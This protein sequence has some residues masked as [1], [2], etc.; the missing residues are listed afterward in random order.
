MSAKSK[1]SKSKLLKSVSSPE[2]KKKCL[3]KVEPDDFNK[4]LSYL[5]YIDANK[6][7]F[8]VPFFSIYQMYEQ[9]SGPNWM[10]VY[11]FTTPD[12]YYIKQWATFTPLKI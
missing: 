6:M 10:N 12:A 8:K 3:T 9:Y 2:L 5:G 7:Q 1:T 11:K 4:S